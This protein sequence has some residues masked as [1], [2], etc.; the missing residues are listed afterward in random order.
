MT[1]AFII[2][3]IGLALVSF[4]IGAEDKTNELN[5]KIVPVVEHFPKFTQRMDSCPRNDIQ[6]TVAV[7]TEMS[8]VPVPQHCLELNCGLGV[9]S[10]KENETVEK[11]TYCGAIR[12]EKN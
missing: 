12:T 5:G 6:N 11:C 8:D 9:Y 2:P 4:T 3:I 1:K 7:P 10:K